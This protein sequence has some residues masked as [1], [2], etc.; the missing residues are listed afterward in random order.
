MT[1]VKQ[2][3][4]S[5]E[6]PILPHDNADYSADECESY[7]SGSEED[8]TKERHIF[9]DEELAAFDEAYL[10]MSSTLVE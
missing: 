3:S 2:L 1:S 6:E 10:R 4:R 8:R 9:P 7:N 5:S